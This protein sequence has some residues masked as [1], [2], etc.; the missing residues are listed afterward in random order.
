MLTIVAL[1]PGGTTGWATYQAE[2]LWNANE[3][4]EYYNVKWNC[5]QLGPGQHH[6]ELYSFLEMQR[7]DQYQLVCE[8]F[9]FRQKARD[10]VVLDSKEYIGVVK[11]Y[12]QVEHI[13]LQ[14][15]TAAMGKGFVTDDKIK[16][17]DLWYPGW[18][19]AMDATRHLLYFMVNSMKRYD[20]LEAWK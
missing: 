20:L 9:E 3:K 14:F 18:P 11:L 5:G 15:Q 16:K 12:H 13:P 6:A 2:T 1:D 17:L 8:S 19:H 7:T 4:Q 10:N